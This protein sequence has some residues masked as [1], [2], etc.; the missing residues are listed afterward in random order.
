MR[1]PISL[2]EYVPLSLSD[3]KIANLGKEYI[4]AFDAYLEANYKPRPLVIDRKFL[5]PKSF[6]GSIVFRDQQFE[7]LPKLLGDKKES[8][9]S[10]VYKNLITML[11]V[12]KI[13]SIKETEIQNLS[14]SRNSFLEIYIKL[15]AQITEKEI[16]L[17]PHRNYISTEE[18][19]NY[20]KGQLN[21]SENIKHNFVL[22]QRSYCR[23]DEYSENNELNKCLKFVAIQLLSITKD[24]ETYSKLK[25]IQSY[26]LE[27]EN[28]NFD[29]N[30]ANNIQINRQNSTYKLSIDL[31]KL[32]LAGLT[33]VPKSGASNNLGIYFDMNQL[34]EAF[35]GKILSSHSATF[36]FQVYIQKHQPLSTGYR[37]LNESH[38]ISA[39]A[40]GTRTDLILDLGDRNLAI[41]DTKYKILDLNETKSLGVSQADVYQILAYAKMLSRPGK[42]ALPVLLYPQPS[43][44]SK[45]QVT[46]LFQTSGEEKV[47]FLVMTVS[48][49][50]DLA[51]PIVREQIVRR[52]YDACHES[53]K[54]IQ[55][56]P[57]APLKYTVPKASMLEAADKKNKY[58]S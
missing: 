50:D 38:F 42:K 17:R 46:R 18:N 43:S 8:S 24:Q 54:E 12:S 11:S 25:T 20:F 14:N 29:Y 30:R 34:F 52:I 5:R 28:E 45:F 35:I 1:K 26:L 31:A 23:F 55:V 10:H 33:P 37:N 51:N 41:I 2:V 48:L 53:Q 47:K 13:V 32:F 58:K 21:L 7:I 22:K 39:N 44:E 15:F 3:A 16:A 40:F 19:L 9:G 4:D 6:V 57:Q 36:K 27:I 56:Q 49:F